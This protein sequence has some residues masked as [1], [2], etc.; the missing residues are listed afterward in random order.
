MTAVISYPV[1]SNSNGAYRQERRFFESETLA[2]AHCAQL[3]AAENAYVWTAGCRAIERAECV[4]LF[5]Q[6]CGH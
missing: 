6:W 2:V 3:P 5:R 1:A 4:K